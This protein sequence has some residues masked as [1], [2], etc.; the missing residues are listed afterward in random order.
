MAHAPFLHLTPAESPPADSESGALATL[1]YAALEAR[2]TELCARLGDVAVAVLGAPACVNRGDT[3]ALVWAAVHGRLRCAWLPPGG[4]FSDRAL[5]LLRPDC[6]VFAEGAAQ[7][8]T[9]DRGQQDQTAVVAGEPRNSGVYG[10]RGYGRAEPFAPGLLLARAPSGQAAPPW[11]DRLVALSSGV[12]GAPAPVSAGADLSRHP[13]ADTHSPLIMAGLDW[14]PALRACVNALAARRPL[15]LGLAAAELMPAHAAVIRHALGVCDASLWTPASLA[16]ALKYL[17]AIDKSPEAPDAESPA[18][19]HATHRAVVSG[20]PW[21][22]ELATRWRLLAPQRQLLNWYATREG[23]SLLCPAVDGAP[24]LFDVENR[25]ALR[26]AP[27]DWISGGPADR[28][29]VRGRVG[30]GSER[31]G[32]RVCW[33]EAAAVLAEHPDVASAWVFERPLQDAEDVVGARALIGSIVLLPGIEP[34]PLLEV[35]VMDFCSARLARVKCPDW[36]EIVPAHL[37]L[38]GDKLPLSER[39]ASEC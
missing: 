20:A 30:A 6:V 26:L 12:G 9:A 23:E 38:P 10:A 4:E 7:E 3:L 35:R 14:W 39:R 2:A 31:D 33:A 11:P 29:L 25:A 17:A 8:A 36:L 13:L 15:W 27:D 24:A 32:V 22:G 16:R 1:S 19:V 21:R 34:T 28:V 5:D 18:A 37:Q